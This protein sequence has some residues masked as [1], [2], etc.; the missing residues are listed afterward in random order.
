LVFAPVLLLTD[1]VWSP[2]E[3]PVQRLIW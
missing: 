1:S 2:K 3:P